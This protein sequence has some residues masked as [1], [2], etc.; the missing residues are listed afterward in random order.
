M[1]EYYTTKELAAS[2]SVTAQTI[3]N[4]VKKGYIPC[5]RITAKTIRFDPDAV[6]AALD[7]RLEKEDTDM[8]TGSQ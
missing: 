5:I 3:K 7:A 6:V 4:W 1:K 8:G 2:L